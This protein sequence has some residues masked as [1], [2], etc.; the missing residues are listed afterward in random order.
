[1]IIESRIQRKQCSQQ[2]PV[3]DLPTKPTNPFIYFHILFAP[4]TTITR[5]EMLISQPQKNKTKMVEGILGA[6]RHRRPDQSRI[7]SFVLV[8][9]D[10]EI[11]TEARLNQ[12]VQ[13]DRHQNFVISVT[14]G[15]HLH[16]IHHQIHFVN[17]T[18]EV[19]ANQFFDDCLVGAL[20]QT[21]QMLL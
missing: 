10:T 16:P 8:S 4:T 5:H 15:R 12:T 1:M 14:F 17:D 9:K 18:Q 2:Q 11:T 21:W 6:R 19:E 7:S 3:S 20:E 13:F